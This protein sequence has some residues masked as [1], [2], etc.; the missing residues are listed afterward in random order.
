[1]AASIYLDHNA[2]TPPFPE[3]LEAMAPVLREHFGNP[4]SPHRF[5]REARRYLDHARDALAFPL[6]CKSTEIVFTS[7]GTESN[8]LA[9]KGFCRA[10]RRKTG[11]HIVTGAVEHHSVLDPCRDLEEEGFSV[12]VVDPDSKGRIH[13]D[14]V[15][16]AIR[17]DTL[18]ISIQHANNE[19]GTIQ[20]IREISEVARRHRI[21]FHADAV[22]SFLKIPTRVDELG[23]D[24]LSVSGHKVNGPKGVG[25]LFIRKG[26]RLSPEIHGGKQER[27]LRAGT[28]NI[29]GAVGFGKAVELG[30][31]RKE[32]GSRIRKIRDELQTLLME[33]IPS[34]RVNGDPDNRLPGSLHMSFPGAKGEA[35]LVRLDLMGVAVSTGS[36]CSTGSIGPSHVLK[37]MGVP[38]EVN[39]CSLRFS[40]G[41]GNTLDDARRVAEILPPIVSELRGEPQPSSGLVFRRS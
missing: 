11:G 30:L 35:L 16:R 13:P 22:Q 17:E 7:G 9:L 37:A 18:L 34:A 25:A 24:L 6:G 40:V 27:G 33:S 5:G 10:H 29:S 31:A 21:V 23:V 12:T 19:V 36:A 39:E 4:S 20:P 38:D 28:E 3:V 2:T 1:M 14:S 41:L 15:E 8:N 32:E 26:I